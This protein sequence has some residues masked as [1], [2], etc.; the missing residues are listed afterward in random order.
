M[1]KGREHELARVFAALGDAT[2]LA[3]VAHL[4][5]GGALS[6]TALAEGRDISRQAIVKHLQVLEAADL[7]VRARQGREVLYT[8]DPRRV[9]EA[10]AFLDAVSAGWDRAIG[11]LRKLVEA[12]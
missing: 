10:R 8:L 6:A 11:R 12:P 9:D 3:L 2:R 5:A 7:V 4:L 1:S